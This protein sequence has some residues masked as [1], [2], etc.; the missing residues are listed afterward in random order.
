VATH[1]ARVL[2]ALPHAQVLAFQATA[3]GAAA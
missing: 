3:V 1:D 2:Q